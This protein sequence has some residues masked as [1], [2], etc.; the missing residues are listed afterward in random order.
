MVEM[1]YLFACIV[2]M[3]IFAGVLL[4]V[5][6][7]IIKTFSLPTY[8]GLIYFEGIHNIETLKINKPP[9]NT[10][11]KVIM[12]MAAAIITALFIDF[13]PKLLLLLENENLLIENLLSGQIISLG[14][15]IMLILCLL[16]IYTINY[17]SIKDRKDS[18]TKFD[19]FEVKDFFKFW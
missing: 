2:L 12:N 11:L 18:L 16:C 15:A 14:K 10:I 1:I 6:L 7:I 5:L 9:Q 19:N 13:C 4:K 3:S 17:F 8:V